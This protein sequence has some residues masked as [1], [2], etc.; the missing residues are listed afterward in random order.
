MADFYATKYLAKPQQ[1][2]T[3]VLGPLINGFRRAREKT[4]A[5]T[6]EGTAKPSIFTV[7]LSKVRTAIFAANRSIWISCC[8]ASLYLHTG[9]TAVKTH[10]YPQLHARRGLYMMHECKRILNKEVAG[11]GLWHAS[12]VSGRERETVLE[13]RGCSPQDRLADDAPPS[14]LP[15]E[16][17]DDE[18]SDDEDH[19]ATA[20]EQSEVQAEAAE[21]HCEAAPSPPNATGRGAPK[22]AKTDQED[23]AEGKPVLTKD[24][25]K[26]L[27]VFQVTVLPV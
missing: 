18:A 10:F 20:A 8:E 15:K 7:A 11:A 1:W 25:R 13:F 3:S 21:D 22:A 2:L 27:Q 4:E 19:D 6:K 9:G 24:E 26:K 14:A 12:L 17:H 16:D 23:S 5:E